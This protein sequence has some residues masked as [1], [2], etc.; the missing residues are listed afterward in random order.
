[1]GV[2][3][4][5]AVLYG[6]SH[7]YTD[8]ENVLKRSLEIREKSGNPAQ[9]RTAQKNLTDIFLISGQFAEAERRLRGWLEVSEKELAPND[10]ELAKGYR[11]LAFA[12]RKMHRKSEAA[13]S[14][15]RANAILRDNRP[16]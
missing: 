14:E 12:L 4:N 6:S 1:V 5:L 2:L 15:A 11:E 8:A 10:P 16:H 7:R 3:N 9:V 13:T